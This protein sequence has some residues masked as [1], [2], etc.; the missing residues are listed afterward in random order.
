MLTKHAVKLGQD[1]IYEK[2]SKLT[3]YTKVTLY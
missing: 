2:E 1:H 3:F